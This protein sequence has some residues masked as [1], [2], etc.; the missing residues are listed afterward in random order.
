[1]LPADA[2]LLVIHV[3]RIGD[4][5]L[6]TP[7]VRALKQA[8]PKGRLTCLLH[9]ARRTLYENLP[10]VD[11]L[12]AITPKTAWLRSRFGGAR[13]D[14]ALVYGNDAPLVRYALRVAGRVIAFRQC[15]DGLNAR[16][17]RA[18]PA[19]AGLHAVHERLLLP[20]ALGVTTTD[21]HLAYLPTTNERAQARAWLTQH[22]YA[23]GPLIGFQVASF[24]TKSYRDWPVDSFIELGRR[25]LADQPGAQILIFGGKESRGVAARITQ[26]LAP[27]A[28][29]VAGQLD[30]RATAAL[31]AQLNLYVGVDTGPTHLAG[32]LGV[33]MVA[34][35]HCR[36][37][38][39]QLAPLGHD[40]LAVI[41]H[42]ASDR[43]CSADTPM[44]RIPVE[45]VWEQARRLLKGTKR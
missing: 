42:P 17:W 43:E 37:R 3:A 28:Q 41:E 9:P 1:M 11:E 32:A 30:L 20:E 39:A 36:H 15:D 35:Y 5:L 10:W 16:L 38:G 19:P 4:T 25:L 12:G 23:T 33:P 45:A 27:H 7:A 40:R 44:D 18:V 14:Y 34:L 8:S 21:F 2:N 31:L 24:P 29:S 26:A 6:V 22:V 13:Y